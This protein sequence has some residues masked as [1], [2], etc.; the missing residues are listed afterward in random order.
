MSNG[1]LQDR[2]VV[3][4][5][6]SSGNGRAIALAVA[7]QG[8]RAVVV[9]DVLAEPREGGRATH[10]VIGG[11]SVFVSCDVSRPESVEEAIAAADPL[12]GVDVLVN[13]AGIVGP[14]AR[15]RGWPSTTSIVCWP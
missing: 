5:G 13:N 6:G 7:A 4:T 3:V 2:V 8:A 15:S 1:L 12:G 10:E 14:R 11:D 9:A